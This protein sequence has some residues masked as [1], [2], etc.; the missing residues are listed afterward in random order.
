MIDEAEKRQELLTLIRARR[1]SISAFVHEVKPRHARLNN[2]SIISSAV[3]TILTAG[4]ALGGERF[5]EGAQ[6]L[7]SL[8]AESAVW[9]VLCLLA[10]ICSITAAVSTNMSRS[11]SGAEQVSKAE[12]GNA[13]LEGLE[14]LVMLGQLPI[15]E[16]VKQYQ[17][18]VAEIP[19][20]HERSA[21]SP[22]HS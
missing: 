6:Q 11:H 19:F 12:A 20:V 8:P 3:T 17:Q 9:R 16:A 4:P 14:V 13:K 2:I 10:M 21:P 22:L 7:L 15:A 18:Y 5:T 1:A